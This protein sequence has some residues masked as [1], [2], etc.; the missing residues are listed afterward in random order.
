MKLRDLSLLPRISDGLTF[1]SAEHV[2]VEASDGGIELVDQGGRVSV[3][4][5]CLSALLLGPG[6]CITHAAMVACAESGCSVL[7]TGEGGVRLYASGLGETRSSGNLLVQAKA[8]GDPRAHLDVVRAMYRMR[9]TEALPENLSLEQIRGREGVRV[10]DA[11]AKAARDHGVEWTGRRYG[12]DWS[13]SSAVNR[14]L[15]TSASCLYGVC[16]AAIVATGLSPALGF[17]HTGKAL[18]FVYDVADLYKADVI[19]PI[20]FRIASERPG[21][22]VDSEVRR[23]CRD[24]FRESNILARIVPDM[25]RLLG[26]RTDFVTSFDVDGEPE[27]V[28]RLWDEQGDLAGGVNYADEEHGDA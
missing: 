10:R 8:W 17:V 1:L 20:A 5:A 12:S 23:A 14:A 24:A 11:Y 21:K 2:R 15:S 18:S 13:A 27:A 16:H 6:T 22:S 9:F 3:P 26:I 19:V 25:Q 7:F 28:G 4:V